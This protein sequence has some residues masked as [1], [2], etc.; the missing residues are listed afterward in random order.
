MSGDYETT[1]EK[2]EYECDCGAIIIGFREFSEHIK[3][4]LDDIKKGK[5]QLGTLFEFINENTD[6]GHDTSFFYLITWWLNIMCG[7]DDEIN[8]WI[9]EDGKF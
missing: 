3:K 2:T 4:H 5:E 9:I 6:Y 7:R 8:D 1:H